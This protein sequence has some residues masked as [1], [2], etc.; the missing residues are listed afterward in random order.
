ML[1]GGSRARLLAPASGILLAGITLFGLIPELRERIG[2]TAALTLVAAGF[3]A[4]AVLDRAGVSVCPSCRHGDAFVTSLVAA[5]AVHAFIDGWALVATGSAAGAVVS[6]AVASAMLLHKIPEGLALGALLRNTTPA[7][8]RAAVLLFAAEGA[9]IVGGLCGLWAAPGNWVSY[10]LALVGGTF[11]F[12]G[13][14][15]LDLHGEHT[16]PSRENSF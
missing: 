10:L 5:V 3:L 1:A 12:L 8:L 14:H 16:K 4:L 2:W 13:W 6:G 7:V 15:A 11:L 9:T